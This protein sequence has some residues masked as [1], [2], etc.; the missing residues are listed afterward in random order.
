MTITKT[1][2]SQNYYGFQDKMYLQTNGLAMGAPTSSI[3]SEIYLQYLENTKIFNI[4]TKTG[5]E[6]YFRYVDDILIIYNKNHIDIGEVLS[7]F[8]SLTP[9]LKFTLEQEKD[10]TLNFLDISI[11]KTNNKFSY[12]IYRKPTTTDT[13]IPN[14]SCHPREHKLAAI[15]YLVNRANTYDLDT[16]KKEAEINTIKQIIRNNG[17]DASA[18]EKVNY[19]ESRQENRTHDNK[20][21]TKFTYVGTDTR[22][23][24]KFFRTHR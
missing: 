22:Q 21:W 16:G 8:N 23:I 10:G 7:S 24:T 4:L 15:R 5:I 20:K 2:L 13:I 9:N 12:G 19:I 3:F 14:D 17:Y 1:I 11:S 18:T 6:A